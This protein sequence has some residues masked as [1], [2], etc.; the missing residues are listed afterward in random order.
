[1]KGLTARA[2]APTK[3]LL[4]FRA[5]GSDGSKAPAARA[6]LVK[7]SRR[8]IRTGRDFRRAA[9][10][11]GG[12]CTFRRATEV[13]T[14]ITLIVSDLRRHRRYFYAVAARDNVSKRLGR[15]SPTARVRTR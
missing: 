13:G 7:Q 6:Y 12:S 1:V 5:T 3:I 15:R 4:S 11:C 2:L 8:P 14:R 10:L 9:A